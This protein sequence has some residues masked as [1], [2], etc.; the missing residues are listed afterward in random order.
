MVADQS[1]ARASEVIGDSP[2]L[3]FAKADLYVRTGRNPQVA[4]EL[5]KR[6]L[7]SRLTP[8]D[9]PRAEAAKLLRQIEGS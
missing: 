1:L 9:P 2:K 8:D 5:L 3:M 7:S 6:Y 4:R